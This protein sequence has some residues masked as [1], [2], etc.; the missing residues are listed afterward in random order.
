MHKGKLTT[1]TR[2]DGFEDVDLYLGDSWIA[3]CFDGNNAK[4]HAK[5]LVKVWNE[6]DGLVEALEAFER[7]IKHGDVKT[8]DLGT[9]MLMG[10][11][12]EK[13]REALKQAKG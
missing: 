1:K 4:E 9:T 8:Q 10:G 13:A 2:R 11:A 12:I 7:A 6:Y 5:R 3:R